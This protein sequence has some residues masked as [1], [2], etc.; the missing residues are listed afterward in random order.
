MTPTRRYVL[1]EK[2]AE[3][4]V[5]HVKHVSVPCDGDL[6]MLAS[7]DEARSSSGLVL[8]PDRPLL[9][10]SGRSVLAYLCAAWMFTVVIAV[11]NSIL[12]FVLGER[13]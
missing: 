13:T 9:P 10:N 6:A 12:L 3:Q 2:G 7:D 11:V 1:I 5:A 8:P 4:V